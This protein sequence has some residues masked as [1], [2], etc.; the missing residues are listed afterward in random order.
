MGRPLIDIIGKRFGAFVVL[1]RIQNHYNG[2]DKT[3]PE[4]WFRVRCDCGKELNQRGYM[5]RHGRV[6]ACPE[7]KPK[8]FRHGQCYTREYQIWNSIKSRAKDLGIE[9]SLQPSDIVIPKRCPLLGIRICSSNKKTSFNSPSVDRLDNNKGYVK[10]NIW[11]ISHKANAMK[12]SASLTELKMLV[13][14][15][16]RKLC[17]TST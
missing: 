12:N 16:E 14:N 1:R 5:L 8:G 2:G 10:S 9:F 6:K 7:C 17:P 3:H 13:K 15:L 11:I 4:A